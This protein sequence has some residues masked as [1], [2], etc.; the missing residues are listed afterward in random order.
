M[1][2]ETWDPQPGNREFFRHRLT[3]D[4]GWLVRRENREAMKRDI[5]GVDSYTLIRRDD[6]GQ[7]I[8]WNPEA[9][10]APLNDYHV[11]MIA[12]VADQELQRHMGE[13]GRLRHW[14]DMKEEE[15]SRWIRQGPEGGGIRDDIYRA[16]RG[17]LEPYTK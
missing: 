12:W 8:D 9:P 4:L 10:P 6:K 2:Q 17:A 13:V 3:G 1:S 5:V 16:I 14:R 15:R 7:I 11:G